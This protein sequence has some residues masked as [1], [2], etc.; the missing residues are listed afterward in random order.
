MGTKPDRLLVTRL[1]APPAG[2]SV[3]LFLTAVGAAWYVRE[4]QR[5][6][7]GPMASNVASVRAAQELEISLREVRHQFDRYLITGEQRHLDQ[8]GC[9]RK[10]TAVALQA[11][12][13]EA[14]TPSERALMGQVRGGYER[15]FA[16]YDEVMTAPGGRDIDPKLDELSGTVIEQEILGPAQQY[17]RINDEMLT[18]A[19][20][21]NESL[22]DRLTAGLVVLAL[23][24]SAAGLLGGWA[25]AVAVRRTIQRTEEGLR[26][27]ADQLDRALPDEPGATHGDPV[28]RVTH[29]VSAILA[30][31]RQTERDALRA[32]QLAWAGQMAAG[33]AHEV[34]NP[35]TS[36][37]LLVQAASERPAGAG[38]VPRELKVLNE[39]IGRLE[40]IV[41]G[42]LDFARPSSPEKHPVELCELLQQ[43]VEAVRARAEVQ[44]VAVTHSLPPDG[45]TLHAD[46]G[47]LRQ[48]VYNLLFNAL[49][50]L[51]GGGHVQLTVTE[52]SPEPG[53]F[54]AC[55][56][57]DSGPGLPVDLGDRIFEPFVSTRETGLGLGLSICRRIVESHG[58]VITAA[59]RAG[60]GAAFTLTL[61]AGAG[62]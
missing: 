45:V 59:N 9:L 23:S 2:V 46:A 20:A 62:T 16:E 7:S 33:I 44:G 42:F 27:A 53:G 51:P 11:A 30:R 32:E 4:M 26:R 29:S 35:L 31:L 3:L 49:D 55:V 38:F 34:R 52:G 43:T 13:A 21:E 18:A 61:P 60:G 19:T 40:R 37:K 57:E 14:G 56:I 24:G 10:R 41:A 50:A 22:A 17:L 25:L 5:T 8:V 48:V 54:V 39:E 28:T 6:V 1:I 47:Q 12:E 58:G 36:M 15:F